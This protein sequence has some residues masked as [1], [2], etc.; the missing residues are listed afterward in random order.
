MEALP[1]TV[2]IDTDVLVD[3]LRGVPAA[4]RWLESHSAERFL[5]PGMVAMELLAGCRDRGELRRTMEFVDGVDVVWPEPS[6]FAMAYDLLSR[7]WLA[8][9]LA[10]PDCLIAATAL[11][12]SWRLYTFNLKHFRVVDGLDVVQPYDRS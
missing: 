10:I 12:R 3:C 6:E 1:V 11:S 4:R 2:L 7:H 8:S 5:I 9:S